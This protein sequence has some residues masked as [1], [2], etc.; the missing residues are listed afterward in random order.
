MANDF[1]FVGIFHK[2]LV[3]NNSLDKNFKGI[4]KRDRHFKN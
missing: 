1:Y 4:F 2:V 3:K